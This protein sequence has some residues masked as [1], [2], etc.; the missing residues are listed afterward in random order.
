MVRLY[1]SPDFAFTVYILTIIIIGVYL[2]FK[3]RHQRLFTIYNLSIYISIF[4]NIVVTPFFF[5]DLA[6]LALGKMDAEPMFP[7]LYESISINNIGFMTFLIADMYFERRHSDKVVGKKLSRIFE[8][9]ISYHAICLVL[10]LFS[11]I[12]LYI[13]FRYNGGF[14]LFNGGR[15]FF[16]NS[17]FISMIYQSVITSISFIG[18]YLGLYWV[19]NRKGWILFLWSCFLYLSTGTR[20]GVI[21]A[22]LLPVMFVAILK[23]YKKI[24][25]EYLALSVI[26]LLILGLFI[27]VIRTS[28][29]DS[30]TDINFISELL[31]GNNFSDIRDGAFLFDGYENNFGAKVLGGKTYLADLMTFIPS[32]FSDFRQEW[33]FGR[34][35][36]MGL[37]GMEEHFGL[38]GG[39]AFEAYVNFRMIG[40]LIASILH[41]FFFANIEKSYTLNFYNKV[42]SGEKIN[43]N[44]V[45]YAKFLSAIGGYFCASGIAMQI[46]VWIFFIFIILFFKTILSF[47]TRHYYQ[48]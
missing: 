18:L 39:I 10:M 13:V 33:S 26:A 1:K 4:T 27:G 11:I 42:Q 43:I 3:H 40:V 38:R 28:S 32:S 24:K 34:F 17:G 12:Y 6:W 19:N 15:T 45:F 2:V 5:N 14:P 35:S 37:F 7:Y 36:T 8:Q 16:Y 29:Y 9:S 23:R 46:Y 31:Y 21:T 48:S 25:I 44:S 41:G 30:D 20:S 47:S 22:V